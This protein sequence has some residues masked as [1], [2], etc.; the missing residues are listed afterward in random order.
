MRELQT[1]LGLVDCDGEAVAKTL[2][3]TLGRNRRVL[4]C[5]V[6]LVVNLGLSASV[7]FVGSVGDE[8]RARRAPDTSSP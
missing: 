6:T 8:A 4:A 1:A 7:P 5:L 3:T 2:S